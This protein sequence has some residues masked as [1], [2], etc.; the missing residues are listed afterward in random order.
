MPFVHLQVKS[1]YSLLSSAAK[2]DKLVSKAKS[3]QFKALAL[4][5]FQVMYG[6]VAF[7]KLCRKYDI[8]PIIG[9]TINVID[10]DGDGLASPIVLLAENNCGYQN[11]LKISSAIQTKSPEGI[12]ERWLRSYSKGLIAITTGQ[13]GLIEKSLLDGNRLKAI[14]LSKKYESIFGRNSF[15]YGIQND[16]TKQDGHLINEMLLLGEELKIPVV[17]TN[18]VAYL[19][20]ED[21]FAY[22]CLQAIKNGDKLSDDHID[23]HTPKENYLKSPMEMVSLFDQYPDA[24]E[25]TLLIAERCQVDLELGV[26]HLP[27]FP[28]P[29]QE[30]ANEYLEH[31]C[32][33]GLYERF[34]EP[35]EIYKDRLAYEL[36]VITRM[37]FSDYFLI[38]WDF[39]K[40]AHENGILTGPGRGSAAGSLVSYV[41]KITDVDPIKHRLLFER[42]LNPERITMPDIDIDF[43]DSKRDDVINYVAN[44]YGKIHVAQIIT[45]GTLAAKAAIRDVGRVMGASPKETDIL[46]KQI[47]VRPG[48]MLKDAIHDSPA[49][50]KAI[51]ENSLYKKIVETAMKIEGLPRHASTHAAGVVLSDQPLTNIVPIQEGQQDVFLTQF[52]MDYLEDLGLLKMD[53]LG[54]RNLT[55]IDNITKLIQREEGYV[56]DFAEISIQDEKTFALLSNGDTTGVFQLE[57]EGMRSVLKRL[58]P[59]SFEDIVAVNALYRPGPMENIPLY[60]DR[61][62]NRS[63]VNYL[64]PDLEPILH[65]T[66][67]VIVYQEQIMEIASKIAGFTLGEADLLRRAVGKKKKEVLDKERH[68]FVEGCKVKGYDKHVANNIY[69]L[70]V[71]FANYGFNRSHAVAY[72]M[73]AYQL[74]YLKANYP[75]Y[76]MTAL[77]TS[78]NGND[79]KVSQYIREAKQM[80][81]HILPP[82]VNSSSYPFIV[83]NGGIR[84]SLAGIKQV[85]L[86]AVKEIFHARKKKKY[87]DLFDFCIRVSMKVVNRRTL[88]QLIF[89]GAMDEFNVDRA[90]L[91]ASL[92]VA[93]EHAELL[94]PADDSQFDLFVDEEFSLKP[95]YIEVEPLKIE[96]KLKYEKE[97]IGFYFSNHPVELHRSKFQ[98][99]GAEYISDLASNMEKRISLG[100]MIVNIRTIRT[101]KGEVM[102]FLVLGDETGEIDAVMFPQIYTKNS[103]LMSVGKVFLF[104]GKVELRQGKKQFVIQHIV[105]PDDINSHKVVPKLFI[106]IDKATMEQHRLLEVK[107]K[108][109][110][111]H[112]NTPVFLYYEVER[113]TVQLPKEYFVS[114]TETC[115]NELIKLLGKENVVLR[116]K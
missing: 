51:D 39:M 63:P 50:K 19:E 101:K 113:R 94:T 13:D 7:F 54:L 115:L 36:S 78:V 69:D 2:L 99:S 93:I 52:S 104:E 15:Y 5:D 80:G 38:V 12:P 116:S 43:P 42:F 24:L 86:S 31:L 114:S 91:L 103:E 55:I 21:F 41:L 1:A 10:D 11:L 4:T 70:I 100:A 60:I 46:S 84:Y 17:A 96:E 32:L 23:L 26:T 22:Q 6:T 79:E 76:F 37:N 45:F 57:S 59:N 87:T 48:I 30:S 67:G 111:F 82:S 83:E 58:K 18:N 34:K 68:H 3:L 28:T 61:K 44:K 108:L 56:V 89:S 73:I 75:L 110:Q 25:N 40:Y 9:L 106:K 88:E 105:L 112:G 109:K 66:Y 71:K 92:D 74:A 98:F 62:H 65:S 77:L 33:R 20:K 64:H 90:T 107:G 47:P 102:A 8:K 29:N 81:I 85:G 27:K 72:S 35:D 97:S 95:K 53:F 16:L 49:L 14:E